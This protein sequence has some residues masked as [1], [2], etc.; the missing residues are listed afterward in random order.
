MATNRIGLCIPKVIGM[1]SLMGVR[2]MLCQFVDLSLVSL[3]WDWD[4]SRD[5][6][7]SAT[8]KRRCLKLGL[9]HG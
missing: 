9:P 7:L 3:D 5:H 8:G 1:H 2:Y 4:Y 6:K